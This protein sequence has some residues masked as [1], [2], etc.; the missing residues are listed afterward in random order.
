MAAHI[1][2]D[3]PHRFI[4]S[5]ADETKEQLDKLCAEYNIS[6]SDVFATLMADRNPLTFAS[7]LER[8]LSAKKEA[9]AV[10]RKERSQL[11]AALKNLSDEDRAKLLGGSV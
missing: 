9:K 7:T 1:Q 11:A 2:P 5:A 8:I 6:Q 3:R 4:V 10:R